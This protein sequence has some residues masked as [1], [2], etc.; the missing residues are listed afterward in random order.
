MFYVYLIKSEKFLDQRYIGFTNNLK[1]RMYEHN[2]GMS[3]YT[4][5]YAPWKLITYI[6][7]SEKSAALEFEMYLKKGSGHAFANKRLWTE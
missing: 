5:K 7:F 4:K 1:Q 2:N 3:S 6:A